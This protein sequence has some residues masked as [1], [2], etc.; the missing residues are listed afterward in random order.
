MA[1]RSIGQEHCEISRVGTD[2]RLERSRLLGGAHVIQEEAETLGPGRRRSRGD[3][4]QLPASKR[5]DSSARTVATWFSPPTR[6]WYTERVLYGTRALVDEAVCKPSRAPPRRCRT[7]APRSPSGLT[8]RR[9][10]MADRRPHATPTRATNGWRRATERTARSGRR[11]VEGTE[12]F[13]EARFEPR[14][15]GG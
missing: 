1:A 9:P 6:C 11:R 14:R 12:R 10:L 2:P 13:R 5:S 7:C 15:V 4:H 3:S 8:A